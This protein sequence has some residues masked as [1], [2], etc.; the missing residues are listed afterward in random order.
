MKRFALVIA[1]AGTLAIPGTAAA[2]NAN[3]AAASAKAKH[4]YAQVTHRRPLHWDTRCRRR[5]SSRVW[6]CRS[7]VWNGGYRGTYTIRVT[8]GVAR[9]TS[10]GYV[11]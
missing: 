7:E 2:G 5:T 3:A 4:R 9:I 8:G 11:R 1:L 10:E 6:H